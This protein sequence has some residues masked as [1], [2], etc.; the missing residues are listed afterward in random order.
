VKFAL[1]R[2]N[3]PIGIAEYELTNILPKQLK[4]EMPTI[5]ELEQ[6]LNKEIPDIPKSGNKK[7]NRMKAVLDKVKKGKD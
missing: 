3:S 7:K 6:E 2:I 1:S 4:A 5:K